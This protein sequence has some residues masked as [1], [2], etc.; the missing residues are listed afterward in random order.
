MENKDGCYTS[1][2]T[3]PKELVDV[4]LNCP[5]KKCVGKCVRYEAAARKYRDENGGCVYARN[6]AGKR[7]GYEPKRYELYGQKVTVAEASK[8]CGVSTTTIRKRMKL[9]LS[10]QEVVE[11]YG[12]RQKRKDR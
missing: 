6:M 4:C 11:R 12:R 8:L 9:G 10:M 2:E 3:L 7:T 1:I 5:R